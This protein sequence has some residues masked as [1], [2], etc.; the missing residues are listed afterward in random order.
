MSVNEPSSTWRMQTSTGVP[1]K[2]VKRYGSFSRDTAEAT[3]EYI[4]KAED[5]LDFIHVGLPTPYYIG[6]IVY[7]GRA[8]MYG[9]PSLV[10]DNISWEGLT[11]SKPIDPFG[12]D[13][14]T[15]TTSAPDGTYDENVKCIVK[16]KPREKGKDKED[17]DSND[18]FTFLQV[19]SRAS[20]EFIAPSIT[21]K[22]RWQR[23]KP[24]FG[25]STGQ[26]F[27]RWFVFDAG[28][29]KQVDV[30]ATILSPL[31]EW[32]VRWPQIPYDYFY[33][34]ILPRLRARVGTVNSTR[35]TLLNNPP[36]DTILFNGWSTNEEYIWDLGSVTTPPISLEMSFIE[37]NFLSPGEPGGFGSG[38]P[39]DVQVTWQHVYRSDDDERGWQ[40]MRLGGDPYDTSVGQLLFSETDHNEIWVP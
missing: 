29:V 40:V 28:E 32:T 21:G 30:P 2:L 20:G 38:T 4:I 15:T 1:A 17:S 39:P 16:Y 26:V 14:A 12:H 34:T 33:N 7:P 23:W 36:P 31:T 13:A 22:A 37:K 35:L 11:D 27:I 5:L 10:V 3:E 18:P 19:S 24:V 8:Y 6:G 9:I 25:G